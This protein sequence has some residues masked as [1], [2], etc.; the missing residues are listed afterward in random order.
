MIV[1]DSI[2]Q[3]RKPTEDFADLARHVFA[4]RQL[5]LMTFF[6]IRSLDRYF[7]SS[8]NFLYFGI[9]WFAL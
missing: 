9:L 5:D 8:F 3:V 6:R 2:G 1:A 4:K 7:S